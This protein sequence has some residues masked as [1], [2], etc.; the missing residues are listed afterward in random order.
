[1]KTNLYSKSTINEIL[2]RFDNDVERFSNLETGQSATIDPLLAMELITRA[3][4]AS[5][6]MIRHV[7]DVGCGAG[8]NTIR[9][10]QVYGRDFDADLL[11]LSKTMLT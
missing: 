2:Q 7:L 6:P 8:N 10:R 11:D 9:L 4:V 3:A 5:M 1:M